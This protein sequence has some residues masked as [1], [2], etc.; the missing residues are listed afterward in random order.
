M[1]SELDNSS[2]SFNQQ[3]TTVQG[4][5]GL[6]KG[7]ANINRSNMKRSSRKSVKP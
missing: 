4:Q 6:D 5:P 1:R 2:G 3:A 7:S